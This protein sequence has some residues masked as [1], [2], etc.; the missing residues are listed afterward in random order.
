MDIENAEFRNISFTKEI[1]KSFAI[2]AA[3]TAGMWTGLLAVGL[4]VN[5]F[6]ELKKARNAKKT[7]TEN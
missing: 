3:V 6:Q 5:K 7:Q 4:A 1:T 2:S